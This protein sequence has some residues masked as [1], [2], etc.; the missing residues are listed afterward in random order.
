M[1]DTLNAR[2]KHREPFRPFAPSLPAERV[3]EFFQHDYPSPFMLLVYKTRPEKR[4]RSRPWTTW[5]APDACN[6]S[7]GRRTRST[8]T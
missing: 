8:T 3:G 6:G 7:N 5:M 4:R 1:K 2:V